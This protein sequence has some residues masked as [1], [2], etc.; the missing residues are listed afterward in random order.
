MECAIY[1]RVSTKGQ[2][3]LN[4]LLQL[5]AYA[6][7][8]GWRIAQIYEDHESAAE[9]KR[10][11]AYARLFADATA[12]GRRW[13]VLLF[14]SLDRFSRGGVYETIHRLKTL[15]AAGVRFVSLQEQYLDTLGPFRD[16]VIAV[17]AAVAAL[18]R[19]RISERVK[20]GIARSQL[21]GKRFGRKPLELDEKRL[22]ALQAKGYS[23]RMMSAA[24][25]V[26]RTTILRRL[27]LLNGAQSESAPAGAAG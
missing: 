21:Q 6:E 12:P 16:A 1:A 14:W 3:P 9:G 27:R 5:R 24:L 26:S 19:D 15:H 4:Q 20:A 23:L 17:L 11:E 18:E 22:A 10:R 13:D 7:S 8:K 2:D 25:K